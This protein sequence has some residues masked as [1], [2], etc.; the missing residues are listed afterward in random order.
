MHP[1]G[2]LPPMLHTS[3]LVIVFAALVT[4]AILVHC[5][6]WWLHRPMRGPGWWAAGMAANATGAMLIVLRDKIPEGLS[7]VGGNAAI[8]GGLLT[9]LNGLYIFADRKLD[10]RIPASFLAVVLANHSYFT[11]VDNSLTHRWLVMA[12]LIAAVK[13]LGLAALWQIG[14]RDGR[15]GTALLALSFTVEIF[16][17]LGHAGTTFLHEQHVTRLSD[18][19]QLQPVGSLTVIIAL[20]INTFGYVLLSANRSRAELSRF[21]LQDPL[22]GLANR[23]VFDSRLE[24][25][26]AAARRNGTPLSLLLFDLDYFKR[27]NDVHGHQ[28]G[29]ALL[30]YFA[31]LGHAIIRSNDDF[32]RLGG[33]EFALLAPGADLAT[34]LEIGERMRNQLEASSLE[35]QGKALRLT[36]SVGVATLGIHGDDGSTLTRAADAALY[37]AKTA[38][39][40]RVV[41]AADQAPQS[42]TPSRPVP[43]EP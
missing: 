2:N 38:G 39:R 10:W 40:N 14:K 41:A 29:D 33:E 22:T 24:A 18:L 7:V 36:T 16:F 42:A 3:T 11:L 19:G 28:A 32:A 17:Y 43:V 31:N 15:W 37:A 12:A 34:A 30:R 1:P 13:L 25:Q 26:V 35:V 21:A 8:L 27:I 6:N 9:M 4:T 5:C 20:M 23:R